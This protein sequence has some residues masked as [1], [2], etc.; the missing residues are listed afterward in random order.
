[1]NRDRQMPNWLRFRLRADAGN[2][3]AALKEAAPHGR[4]QVRYLA[5]LGL[6]AI[7]LAAFAALLALPTQAQS[8]TTFVTNTGGSGITDSDRFQ[9]QSFETGANEGG[10]TVSQVDILLGDVS[11]KSTSVSIKEDNGGEPGNLVTTLTNPGT[12]TSNQFNTFTV[13]DIITLDANTTYWLTVNEGI[14]SDR[15]FVSSKPADDELSL[16]GWGIGDGSLHRT[17][18]MDSW[19]NS[20]SS[21]M[22][23]ILGTTS[24]DATLSDLALEEGG[25]NEITLTPPFVTGT[26]SYTALVANSVSSITLTPTVNDANATVEYL[27]AS[28]ASITDTDTST[29]ALDAPLAVLGNTFKVKV[30]AEAGGANTDTYTVVVT[31]EEATVDTDVLVSNT[32]ETATDG[33]S[34]FQA[35][36]FETGA[37]TGEFT[38]S[39]VQLLLST[40]TTGGKSTIVRIRE[41]DNG[42]PATSTPLATLTNPGTLT[43]DSLNT[44]TA[45]VGTTLAAST[46]YWITV[47]EGIALNRVSFAQ[48]QAD[49]ETGETGWSIGNRRIWR[50]NE[51]DSWTKIGSFSLVIAIKGTAGGTTA[52]TDATLSDLALVDAGGNTITL[53]PTFESNTINYTASVANSTDSVTLTA[54]KNDANATA[55]ITSDD[56]TDTPDKAVL[57]LVVGSNTITVT[58]TA[59]NTTTTLTYTVNVTRTDVLVSNTGQ[60]YEISDSDNI[61]AQSFVTGSRVGGYTISEV[62]L[63]LWH[64]SGR[65]TSVSIKENNS[66]NIPSTLVATLTNPG[67]LTSDSLNTFTAPTGTTLAAGKTYWITVN[68]GIN[69]NRVGFRR[70]IE[71]GKTG[72]ADWSIGKPR[73]WKEADGDDWREAASAILLI[74]IKAPPDSTTASTDATL[75]SL[76]L[77]DADDNTVTLNPTFASNTITY[78]ASVANE[79]DSVALSATKNDSNA[80]VII[81]ND[82]DT[83]TPNQAELDLNVGSNTLT[84]TVTAEDSTTTETYTVRVTRELHTVTIAAEYPRVGAG[85][86]DLVFM[87]TRTSAP[88]HALDVTVS[89][90]QD[91]LWLDSSDLSHTVTFIAGS[92]TATLTLDATSISLTPDATGNLTATAEGTNIT[93][94]SDTVEMISIATPPITVT[95]DNSRYTFAE[96]AALAQMKIYALATLDPIYPRAPSRSFSVRFSTNSA[97]ANSVDD[98]VPI[99]WQAIFV[100]ADYEFVSDRFVASKRL[101]DNNGDYFAVVNDEVYEG[102]TELLY[103]QIQ[104]F[105]DL[106]P[107]DLVRFAY[108][109]GTTCVQPCSDHEVSITDSGDQPVLSLN[110][111]PT[112]I[113]EEDDSMTP[114]VAENVSILTVSAASPKTFSSDKTIK[115]VFTGTAT[116]GTRYTVSP[117]DTDSNATGHQV[118]LPALSPSV[119]VTITAASNDNADG[120]K[121]IT[122]T[123]SLGGR[124]FGSENIGLPDDDLARTTDIQRVNSNGTVNTNTTVAGLFKVRIHFMPSATGLLEEELEVKGGTIDQFVSGDISGDN[125]WYVDILP[126]QGVTSVTVRVPPDV[127]NGGNP[128]AEVTYDAVPPLTLVFTTNANEPVIAQFLVTVTFSAEVTE[129]PGNTEGDTTWYFSPQEDLVISH[130]DFVRH[131][132]GSQ[133]ESGRVWNIFV[134]PYDSPGTTTITLPHQRVATGSNTDFWNA[135]ASIEV[136][137]GR[138]S[139]DFELDTYTVDEGSNLTVKVTLDAD[140]LNTVEIPLTAEG[141]GDTSDAD[142]SGVPASLTFNTGETEKTFTFLATDDNSAV[143]GKSVKIAI[144]T[145]LPDIIKPGTTVETTVTI[146]DTVTDLNEAPLAPD[147]PTVSATSGSTT[148]LDVSWTAPTNTGRPSIDS[149]DLR[150]RVGDT[151]A[152]TK[153]PQNVVSTNTSIDNLASDTSYQV[154]V[155][156]HNQ[157]GNSPWSTSQTGTTG[158]TEEN[159]L[160][161][162]TGQ[163][164]DGIGDPASFGAQSFSTGASNGGYTIS[165]VRIRLNHVSPGATTLVSIREDNNGEPGDPVAILTNPA[166]LTSDSV[167]TFTATAGTRLDPN[168]T[169]WITTNEGIVPTAFFALTV[170]YDETADAGWSIGNTRLY[171]FRETST[172]IDRSSWIIGSKLLMIAIKGTAVGGASSDAT[173]RGLRVNDG[174]NN[175]TLTP[176]FATGTVDYTASVGNAVTTV[177]L[178]A[179]VN[180]AAASVSAVTLNGA[181]ITDRNLT[182]GTTVPS[183]RVGSN[184]IVVTV[185][186]ENRT[187]RTYTVSVTREAATGTPGV[188]VSKTALAVTEQDTTGNIYTLVLD[189]QP[190]ASVTVTVGGHSGTD[191]TPSPAILTFTTNNWNVTHTVTVTAVDDADATS[192]TLTLTHNAT[193]TDRNYDRITIAGVTVTVM[194]NDTAN[195]LVNT[196]TL[197]VVEENSGTFTV[198]LATLP[199]ANVTVSVSSS[200]T[201]AAT[202]FPASLTFT[203]T[204]WNVTQTVTVSAVN[205]SDTAPETVTVTLRAS[206]GGYTGK[207]DSVSVSVTDNDTANSAPTFTEGSS[208]SRAF[209]ETLSDATVATASDI[210]AVVSATD[211]DTSDKLEYRLEGTEATKFGIISTSGQ[212]R[213]NVG[214]KYDHEAKPSYAVTVRVMDGNGGS[215]TITV[216]LNVTD[217][218]EAPL[219]PDAPQVSATS[220]STTSLDVSWTAPTNTGRPGIDSYDLQYRV[221]NSGSFTNGPQDVTRTSAAIGNLAP[222]TSYQVHVRATN[223]EGNSRWSQNGDGTTNDLTRD[224]ATD[225]PS[226]PTGLTARTRGRTQIDLSWDTPASDGGTPITGYRIEVSSDG[227]SNWSDLVANTGNANRTYPHTGLTAGDTRHYRVSAVNANGTGPASSVATAQTTRRVRPSTMNLYFTESYGGR[228]ESAEITHDANSIIGDCSGEKY[229]R[230]YWNGPSYPAADRWEVRAIPHDGGSV[231]QIRV[232]YRNDD[233]EWPEFI[234]KARFSA[235]QGE[236][237][238]ISFAV[239]GRYGERWSAWGPTS[240]LHCRHTHE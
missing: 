48:T 214:E 199:S 64:V 145:P 77:E 155:R 82:D 176:P 98:F 102:S 123:G 144:G 60:P 55:A 181:T 79:I 213:T 20:T 15:V 184:E 72:E 39:E 22:M 237:S 86:E 59:V 207:T 131:Q 200:D 160:V 130:G 54:T 226:T 125:V 18:E 43:A 175:L 31:R 162:N 27:D 76:A 45:P 49:D 159:V 62:D 103:L 8:L 91:Q 110:A 46:T 23:E 149:Y 73:L 232:R 33:T 13:P 19:S 124:V 156:A 189:S 163:T 92:A 88:M 217:R 231:S 196:P 136:Q 14:S 204:N 133:R 229:F 66:S 233:P 236:S 173:L 108:P 96:N 152:W 34:S 178:T 10:Y 87:L 99:D 51:T 205:D 128:A 140:P 135:E 143:D 107:D 221:G 56:D 240:V 180:H 141:Q 114:G 30:T 116:Y 165:E 104:R 113:S 193:S 80:T 219:A 63:L 157:D 222:N 50:S 37:S 171:R 58:V 132:R 212:L 109:D 183:L 174:T 224:P 57:A 127:V 3:D 32:A 74:A 53:D 78:T 235:G 36:R 26:K 218:N 42:E 94:D 177:T 9:A 161:S 6:T 67:T 220:G 61:Q 4:L 147:A 172:M 122:A 75:R 146:T 85:I 227:G 115:L 137:A 139:V 105:T 16:S 190:T 225:V 68:E 121:G 187:T 202:V 198:K 21:L 166:S 126:D 191:V 134:Q 150:Y 83:N 93:G 44:F 201:R 95:Y 129:L 112:S 211:T 216:T 194:D 117:A 142:Y 195:L 206:G 151:G 81:T 120:N 1:M 228:N 154:Q 234:G 11:G 170:S 65:N 5:V 17:S 215:D 167:N 28:D 47:N 118:T 158:T 97:S 209:S 138:R 35:Q 101:Q 230:A 153:R 40:S 90:D 111:N 52:S 38:I 203:T 197:T 70:T 169:Y 25:G 84:V 210:G 2:K 106:T 29:P 208:T 12:L 182:D 186:A 71:T 188:T 223:D 238:S 100:N 119:Q 185:T 7:L 41:D 192:D 24:T 89:I 179:T 164:V 239:R 148:S 69:T 168:T